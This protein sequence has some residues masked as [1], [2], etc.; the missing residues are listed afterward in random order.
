MS[1]LTFSSGEDP[2]A[3]ARA[4]STVLNLWLAEQP[5]EDKAP[6]AKAAFVYTAD[7]ALGSVVLTLEH[8]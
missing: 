6:P 8:D 4:L 3:V 1:T 5:Q 7:G 2:V